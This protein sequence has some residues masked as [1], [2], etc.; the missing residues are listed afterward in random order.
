MTQDSKDVQ[1]AVAQTELFFQKIPQSIADKDMLGRKKEIL[2]TLIGTNVTTHKLGG[3]KKIATGWQ[4]KVRHQIPLLS[5][6]WS[7]FFLKKTVYS[8]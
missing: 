8:I 2:E 5:F 6:S 7:F 4:F 1:P 3:V